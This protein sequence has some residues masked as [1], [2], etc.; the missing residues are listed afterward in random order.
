MV[1]FKTTILIP[2]F[3]LPH[4][5]FVPF[6][7]LFFFGGVSW[8]FYNISVYLHYCLLVILRFLL[9]CFKGYFW[10]LNVHP[11]LINFYCGWQGLLPF[12]DWLK[13]FVPQ[14]RRSQMGFVPFSLYWWRPSSP[15][16]PQIFLMSTCRSSPHTPIG[17]MWR[18]TASGHK[19]PSCLKLP[20]LYDVL[21][22]QTRP[23]NLKF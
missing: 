16:L 7:L 17:G 1:E 19:P 4:L 8:A 23:S 11:L 3:Y 13:A 20:G 2:V 21:L 15:A 18:R 22:A 14:K 5:F 12:P 10:F 9:L 6:F